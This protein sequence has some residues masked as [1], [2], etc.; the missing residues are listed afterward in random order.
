MSLNGKVL[1]G[2]LLEILSIFFMK[3]TKKGHFN[4]SRTSL[5]PRLGV[6]VLYPNLLKDQASVSMSVC[7]FPFPSLGKL[8]VCLPPPSLPPSLAGKSD[9]GHGTDRS[10]L[11]CVVGG[12]VHFKGRERDK[13]TT[14]RTSN[15]N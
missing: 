14:R 8:Q 13:P 9:P 6:P 5:A 4:S 15:C 10:F 3:T 11:A 12:F 7:R 1:D 2:D